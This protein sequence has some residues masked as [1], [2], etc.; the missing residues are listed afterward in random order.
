M[1]LR[2]ENK[3]QNRKFHELAVE[4]RVD[5][6]HHAYAEVFASGDT[7]KGE[8]TPFGVSA[9]TLS[10]RVGRE[11][12][13]ALQDTANKLNFLMT[14][15]NMLG[16]AAFEGR[17]RE[18]ALLRFEYLFLM[19]D[20]EFTQDP[21][22]VADF[23]S[24]RGKPELVRPVLERLGEH[25]VE[26]EHLAERI[27][28]HP[29]FCRVLG[30]SALAYRFRSRLHILLNDFDY[31]K[32]QAARALM[33]EGFDL[34]ACDFNRWYKCEQD[35]G[36]KRGEKPYKPSAKEARWL[37]QF[38]AEHS[39]AE[40]V[41]SDA[42]E[43]DSFE[44]PNE[45]ALAVCDEEDEEPTREFHCSK[46]AIVALDVTINELASEPEGIL[47]LGQI[48]P[49]TADHAALR[50]DAANL[51]E[52]KMWDYI[53]GGDFLDL[54]YQLKGANPHG[55]T[56]KGLTYNRWALTHEEHGPR[57]DPILAQ[58]SCA[59]II[60]GDLLV[61]DFDAAVKNL[62]APE[63]R[64]F[65]NEEKIKA[66]VV[67]AWET[68][69]RPGEDDDRTD[70]EPPRAYLF[71][72]AERFGEY[73]DATPSAAPYLR[74]ARG[75]V[76]SML[77]EDEGAILGAI[78]NFDALER[79]YTKLGI[80][81]RIR[82]RFLEVFDDV[83][84]RDTE[85]MSLHSEVRGIVSAI[86]NP[87]FRKHVDDEAIAERLQ[88]G[89]QRTLGKKSKLD[90][91]EDESGSQKFVLTLYQNS[92]LRPYL[93]GRVDIRRMLDGMIDDV[94]RGADALLTVP[95]SLRNQGELSL[96]TSEVIEAYMIADKL[97]ELV[98]PRK[99]GRLVAYLLALN[100]EMT[101]GSGFTL[102]SLIIDRMGEDSDPSYRRPDYF[103]AS[104]APKSAQRVEFLSNVFQR[105]REL[106]G[107]DWETASTGVTN[108]VF[109]GT[110]VQP[111]RFYPRLDSV[112]SLLS[113]PVAELLPRIGL[114][115]D[116]IKEHRILHEFLKG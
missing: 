56:R 92:R 109:R 101:A 5:L 102:T 3:E 79:V 35:F 81:D 47:W 29:I 21:E 24:K 22:L 107:L 51:V 6:L 27:I 9:E 60:A 59:M 54:A 105:E 70:F 114:C 19:G 67:L 23:F 108:V 94:T 65:R 16:D 26:Y 99:M 97:R 100:S 42:P 20:A 50:L 11:E 88:A 28:D 34:Q 86:Q 32:E 89:I 93:D 111:G 41:P 49:L 31:S 84:D 80:E 37:E 18:L 78:R 115:H 103:P 44:E 76:A 48:R 15:Y 57:I 68:L 8:F 63:L 39:G 71:R 61:G 13:A 98:N 1:K 45:T 74:L 55:R 104:S 33:K 106:G 2:E 90:P 95:Y 52:A 36:M 10:P 46:E 38:V 62:T 96:G 110:Y 112:M 75:E 58:D 25:A 66:A 82:D 53:W 91:G 12:R 43:E 69:Q 40:E 83:F 72:I 4:Q 116:A 113:S 30:D 85:Y 7:P 77:G 17:V 14:R 64:P 87:T 73:L